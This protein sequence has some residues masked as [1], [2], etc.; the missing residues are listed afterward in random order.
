MGVMAEYFMTEKGIKWP[1]G[2]APYDVYIL[3]LGENNIEAAKK[4]RRKNWKKKEKV[5]F[6]TTA[7]AKF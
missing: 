6:L 7:W 5:S 2:V 4:S 3:V 1:K